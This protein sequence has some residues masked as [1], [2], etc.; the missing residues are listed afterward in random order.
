MS[1]RCWAPLR[2]SPKSA[3]AKRSV[4]ASFLFDDIIMMPQ[5]SRVTLLND[6]S[7]DIITTALRGADNTL[8][9]AL[10]SAIGARQRRMIE[11]DLAAG[12]AGVSTREIAV[13]RRTIAQEAIRLAG[14]DQFDAARP[15]TQRHRP[16]AEAKAA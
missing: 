11:S 5:R 10:L 8:R 7:G 14:L 12:E 4:R 15:K 9:E 2:A 13:A 16:E 6:I 3:V 1:N